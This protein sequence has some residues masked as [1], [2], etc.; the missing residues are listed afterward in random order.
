[1]RD[2]EVTN[3]Q[4]ALANAALLSGAVGLKQSFRQSAISQPQETTYHAARVAGLG[5]IFVLAFPAALD[6]RILFAYTEN[7][8]GCRRK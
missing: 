3:R 4:L 1:M 6:F 5:R 7:G 2:R 8:A